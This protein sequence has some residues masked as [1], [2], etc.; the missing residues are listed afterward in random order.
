MATVKVS[1]FFKQTVARW[2]DYYVDFYNYKLWGDQPAIFGRDAPLD[3]V[4]I[5][6]IHLSGNETVTRRWQRLDTFYRTNLTNDPDNDYWLVYAF[7]EYKPNG[8]EYLLLTVLGPDAHSRETWGSL[9]RN[10]EHEIVT[11]WI[12]GRISYPEPD[13]HA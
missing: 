12:Q 10:M 8:G 4:D 3:L 1:D 9:L 6:H 2:H 13:E 7:D 5:H 11:P